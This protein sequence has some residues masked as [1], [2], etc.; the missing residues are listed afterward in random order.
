[1]GASPSS[2]PPPPSPHSEYEVLRQKITA[3]VPTWSEDDV[4]TDTLRRSDVVYLEELLFPLRSLGPT[5]TFKLLVSDETGEDGL[6]SSLKR[7]LARSL[8]DAPYGFG[9]A[10]LQIGSHVVHFFN[11]GLVEIKAWEAKHPY[12]FVAPLNEGEDPAHWG[13]VANNPDNRLA[14]CHAIRE[15]NMG[16][17]QSFTLCSAHTLQ[18]RFQ[19]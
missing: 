17:S 14:I 4:W 7:R 19:L 1:M 15:W 18:T 2:A 11:H 10:A 13:Q 12:L 16:T 9:H 8:G 6:V 5:F 3:Y